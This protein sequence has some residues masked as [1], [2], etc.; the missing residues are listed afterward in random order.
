M[1]ETVEFVEDDS[2]AEP[3]ATVLGE[4]ESEEDAVALA[5]DGKAQFMQRGSG[6]YAWWV[7]RRKGASVAEFISDSKSD[8]EFVLDLNSGELIEIH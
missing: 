4:F 7:V 3:R 1:F 5:R 2:R 8:K 6:L